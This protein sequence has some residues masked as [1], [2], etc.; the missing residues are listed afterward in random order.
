MGAGNVGIACAAFAGVVQERRTNSH[1]FPLVDLTG[2]VPRSCVLQCLPRRCGT[3]IVRRD[4]STRD[5]TRVWRPSDL[6]KHGLAVSAGFL[7]SDGAAS[8]GRLRSGLAV[9]PELK[10]DLCL[11]SIHPPHGTPQITQAGRVLD[12]ALRVWRPMSRSERTPTPG[13]VLTSEEVNQAARS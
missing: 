13:P 7:G 11:L 9:F 10:R 1:C 3:P 2:A 4:D 12:A 8:R 5:W 6:S